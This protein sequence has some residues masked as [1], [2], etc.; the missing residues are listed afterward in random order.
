LADRDK[1]K[2]TKRSLIPWSSSPYPGLR[3]KLADTALHKTS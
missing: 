1:R 3:A 2:I